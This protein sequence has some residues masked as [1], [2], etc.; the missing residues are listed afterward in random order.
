[1]IKLGS[2]TDILLPPGV[3]KKVEVKVGD[4]VQGG[5]TI[6]ARI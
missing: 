2:R 6:L 5:M 1:M 3:A 4:A